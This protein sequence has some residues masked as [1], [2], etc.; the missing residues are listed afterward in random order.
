MDNNVQESDAIKARI[1]LCKQNGLACADLEKSF[2]ALEVE[3]KRRDDIPKGGCAQL[4]ATQE[5]L[6]KIQER[7]KLAN[8]YVCINHA[9]LRDLIAEWNVARGPV[10]DVLKE[11]SEWLLWMVNQ[12]RQRHHDYKRLVNA[13]AGRLCQEIEE[14]DEVMNLEAMTMLDQ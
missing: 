10:K 8:K 6:E 7:F 5:A 2:W 3:R 4:Q 11:D 13:F 12:C 9:N 14:L 1:V